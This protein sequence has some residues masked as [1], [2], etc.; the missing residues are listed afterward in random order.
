MVNVS[1][2]REVGTRFVNTRYMKFVISQQGPSKASFKKVKS[3]STVQKQDHGGKC[4]V[5]RAVST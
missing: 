2:Y 1:V 4:H 3:S 5:K